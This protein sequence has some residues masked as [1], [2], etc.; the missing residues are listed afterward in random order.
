MLAILTSPSIERNVLVFQFKTGELAF[1]IRNK[2]TWTHNSTC[3]ADLVLPFP[4]E[5]WEIFAD[6]PKTLP[7]FVIL[8]HTIYTLHVEKQYDRSSFPDWM[9]FHGRKVKLYQ[10]LRKSSLVHRIARKH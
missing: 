7:D 3:N 8:L 9:A 6:V 4:Y 10:M 5:E 2:A 1:F